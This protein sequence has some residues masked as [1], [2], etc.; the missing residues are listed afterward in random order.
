MATHSISF[1][2]NLAWHA[3]KQTTSTRASPILSNRFEDAL[4]A[5][6]SRC[7]WYSC[8]G[9]FVLLDLQEPTGLLLPCISPLPQ[10]KAGQLLPV[11]TMFPSQ[12][13]QALIDNMCY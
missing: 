11:L 1:I 13:L 8:L 5:I 12:V 3:C 10:L 6:Q 9:C 7:P 2:S 4:S